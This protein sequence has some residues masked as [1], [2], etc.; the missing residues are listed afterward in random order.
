MQEQKGKEKITSWATGKGHADF[1][2]GS[3]PTITGGGQEGVFG[4]WHC[5][6]D[7]Y[8]EISR[9]EPP[10]QHNIIYIIGRNKKLLLAIYYAKDRGEGD[11]GGKEQG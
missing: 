10:P 8:S 9:S 3:L 2:N 6:Q 5:L 11:L 1:A 7:D 4:S